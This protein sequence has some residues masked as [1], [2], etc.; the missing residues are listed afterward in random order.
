[1]SS[2]CEPALTSLHRTTQQAAM[3]APDQLVGRARH[4]GATSHQIADAL[5][6][7]PYLVG[8]PRSTMMGVGARQ[9]GQGC[10]PLSRDG[11][12]G[13]ATRAVRVRLTSDRDMRFGADS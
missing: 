9:C 11:L 6:V 5:G 13:V 12:G 4:A 2:R 10:V 7:T 1:M 8:R 3:I